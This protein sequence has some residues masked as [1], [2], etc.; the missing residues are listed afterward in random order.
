[1]HRVFSLCIFRKLNIILC[2]SVSLCLNKSF[3][4]SITPF[5]MLSS[6]ILP[7]S[8]T[9]AFTLYEQKVSLVSSVRSIFSSTEKSTTYE[10]LS[11]PRSIF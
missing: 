6:V 2:A 4:Y 3:P 11:F 5:F 9:F 7:R 1:M 10:H 8:D